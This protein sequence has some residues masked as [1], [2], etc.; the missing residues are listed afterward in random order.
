V[1]SGRA[2]FREGDNIYQY[3][4]DNWHSR[5][6]IA[7]RIDI[8]QDGQV[9]CINDNGE[10][11]MLGP[12]GWIHCGSP[13]A[14]DIG[15]YQEDQVY[16]VSR[17]GMVK[18]YAGKGRWVDF[19][20]F[21]RTGKK[22]SRIDAG[23]RVLAVVTQDGELCLINLKSGKARFIEQVSDAEDVSFSIRW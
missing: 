9:W 23:D 18:R 14:V 13:E 12:G 11:Y 20:P 1:G 19:A 6:G 7:A 4:N 10:V 3:V 5:Q 16:V 2:A 15:C 17:S 22:A 8:G 21:N